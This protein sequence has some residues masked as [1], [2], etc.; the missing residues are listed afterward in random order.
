ML[1]HSALQARAVV[2]GRFE[3]IDE[4]LACCKG[5]RIGPLTRWRSR[6]KYAIHPCWDFDGVQGFTCGRCGLAVPLVREPRQGQ[7]RAGKRPVDATNWG[8]IAFPV[9]EFFRQG[10]AHEPNNWRIFS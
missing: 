10:N 1:L 9:V 8:I 5:E 6:T 4:G 7:D 3:L 2:A